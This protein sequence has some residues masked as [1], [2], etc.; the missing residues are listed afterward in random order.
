MRLAAEENVALVCEK[1][2]KGRAVVLGLCTK[3]LEICFANFH[4]S[5]KIS[6]P[7][8]IENTGLFQMAVCS[9]TGFFEVLAKGPCENC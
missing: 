7:W 8:F 3:G 2:N 5:E 9:R 6:S 1:G 4:L